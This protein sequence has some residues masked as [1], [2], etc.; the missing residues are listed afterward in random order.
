M[1]TI[2]ILVL[3]T[4]VILWRQA[5]G[6]FCGEYI[7]GISLPISVLAGIVGFGLS[8]CIPVSYKSETYSLE[9]ESLQ[10]NTG[11]SGEMILGSGRINGTMQ[12]VA[13]YKDGDTHRMMMAE[14]QNAT[15]KFIPTGATPSATITSYKFK[16]SIW[17]RWGMGHLKD[18]VVVF[19]V[20]NGSIKNDIILDAK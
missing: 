5:D 15:I 11:T 13:Y 10:D 16:H 4:N 14:Y 9:L 2:F 3:A 8:C 17:L 6:D 12:Y 18:W 19:N 7:F 20:P 1:L